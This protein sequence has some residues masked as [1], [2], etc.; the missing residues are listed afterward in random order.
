MSYDLI[1][2][3]GRIVDGTG[4]KAY[5][6]D[7]AVQDGRIARIGRIDGV[8][9]V[10]ADAA[11]VYDAEGLVVAPGFIDIHTHYDVQPDWDPIATPSSARAA[12]Y[13]GKCR[14]KVEAYLK[15]LSGKMIT[16]IAFG[17]SSITLRAPTRAI[18]ELGPA[19]MLSSPTGTVR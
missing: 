13:C 16:T 2:R 1:I 8:D 10:D 14:S 17:S 11:R 19:M 7:L 5:S 9:G 18:A 3:G 15:A 6:A 12:R 4:L